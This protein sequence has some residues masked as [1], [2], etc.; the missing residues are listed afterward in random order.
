MAGTLY[1]G[2]DLGKGF[3][4]VAMVD[5]RKER[6]GEPYR[7]GRGRAGAELV[8]KRAK[9]CGARSEDVVVTIES[10]GDY[11]RELVW[12]F[13]NAG[14][15]VYLAQPKKA[16]DLRKF[17]ADHTKT[18]ITDAEALA[19]MPLVDEGLRPVW[20]APVAEQM[21][22]RLCR[23]RWKYRCRIADLK[24][25]LSMLSEMVVPGIDGVMPVRY[26]KSARLFMRRYL[27]PARARRLGKRRLVE[28]MTRSAWGKFSD[29]KAEELW[30]CIENAP[31]LGWQVEDL[32]LEVNVQLDELEMLE[33]QVE[34]LDERI[35][36]L[37]SEVDPEQRLMG[38]GGLG[39]FLAAAI[40]AS[41]G[42][43]VRRRFPT[44]KHLV[45]FAGL[46]PRVKSSA[47]HTKPGQGITKRGNPFLRAW[48]YLGASCARTYD[49]ELAAYY[50]RLRD[51]GKHYNVAICATAARLME[52]CYGTLAQGGVVEIEN[53]EH[54]VSAG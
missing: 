35:A 28:L 3:H 12:A 48:A 5:G 39:E 47:G 27:A 15:R 34:R 20:V 25:R 17:Y 9:L 10:T 54:E 4:Q 50:H 51:R 6:V 38:I 49:N 46:A 52:R 45:S 29:R 7:I 16:H 32:L 42:V 43:D 22:L 18:D 40:T 36:E 24:R 8:L 44:T 21:L 2:I 30:R 33:Q 31:E 41:I 13:V 23:L 1:V 11:W 53:Q 37:Y 26:S 14:C 19:R